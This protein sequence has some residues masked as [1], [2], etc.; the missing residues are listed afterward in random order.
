MACTNASQL[1]T[2]MGHIVSQ[3]SE[4][5][6]IYYVSLNITIILTQWHTALGGL[7]VCMTTC[8]RDEMDL[9]W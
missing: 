4:I 2:Y 5:T 8:T 9:V 7:H 6:I 3:K 1:Q